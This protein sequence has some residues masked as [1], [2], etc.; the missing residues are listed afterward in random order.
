LLDFISLSF[1]HN[2][3]HA[4][5]IQEIGNSE[6]VRQDDTIQGHQKEANRLIVVELDN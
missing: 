6:I 5:G 2:P 1:H 3:H 4:Q